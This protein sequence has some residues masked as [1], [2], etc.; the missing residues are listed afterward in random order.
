[1]NDLIQKESFIPGKT[2]EEDFVNLVKIELNDIKRSF[3][4]IGFRLREANNN[5]YYEKL[6]F[7]NISECAEALFGFKK[8][9]TYELMDIAFWFRSKESPMCIDP[10]YQDYNQSQLTLFNSIKYARDS[11]IKMSSP[12]DSIEKLRKAKSYWNK[13]Q[14]GKL[15]TYLGYGRCGNVDEF[16]EKTKEVNP[17]LKET[18]SE[19]TSKEP[20]QL[21]INENSGYPEKQ[22]ETIPQE[23]PSDIT[24]ENNKD[25]KPE[26][27]TVHQELS[28]LLIA[29]CTEHYKHMCYKTIFDPDDK[30]LGVKVMPDHLSEV[31]VMETL[32]AFN[33]NRTEIKNMFTRY[34]VKRIAYFDYNFLCRGKTIGEVTVMEK[35]AEFLLDF[36]FEEWNTIR[37]K[38]KQKKG[39]K[40]NDT[41][42]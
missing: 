3:F 9:T 15:N 30:G 12:T 37:P 32:K 7:K 14:R 27:V 22:E 21:S 35:V 41:N 23:L 39:K 36:I 26:I 38:E 4:K 33:C 34:F 24:I 16:I 42:I 13:L 28:K 17:Q 25:S 19:E 1:M 8:S 29:H 10:K 6:G 31:F 40:K 18:I 2:L 20:E 5:R 11:F